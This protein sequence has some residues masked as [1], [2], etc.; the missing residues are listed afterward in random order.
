MDTGCVYGNK[1]TV[2]IVK[3]DAKF[4]LFDDYKQRVYSYFCVGADAVPRKIESLLTSAMEEGWDKQQK[5]A[6]KE[7][8]HMMDREEV[9]EKIRGYTSKPGKE[10]EDPHKE[11]PWDRLRAWSAFQSLVKLGANDRQLGTATLWMYKMAEDGNISEKMMRQFGNM[12]K[13]FVSFMAGL[14]FPDGM[15]KFLALIKYY[16]KAFNGEPFVPHS[17]HETILSYMFAGKFEKALTEMKQRGVMKDK[18][19]PRYKPLLQLYLDVKLYAQGFSDTNSFDFKLPGEGLDEW[20]SDT[21]G[22]AFGKGG[23]SG[24]FW[25]Q[26]FLATDG[27]G[28]PP[29]KERGHIEGWFKALNDD[30]PNITK[31]ERLL[32][33]SNFAREITRI[34]SD[35]HVH[36]YY[37]KDPKFLEII[38]GIYEDLVIPPG[39]TISWKHDK[40]KDREYN[41]ASS[42]QEMREGLKKEQEK[43]PSCLMQDIQI[44]E[45]ICQETESK[46]S[47]VM[48]RLRGASFDSNL[49]KSVEETTQMNIENAKKGILPGSDD[50]TIRLSA[51][52]NRK[53]LTE[54]LKAT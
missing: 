51:E 11:N 4:Q 8:I 46:M 43:D 25:I 5:T 6:L 20:D 52:E 32:F 33:A 21:P 36:K 31:D 9:L 50:D 26:K 17:D 27:S 42:V 28:N 12:G 54:A 34:G 45:N 19:D 22:E 1:L 15:S 39:A 2:A 16:R 37:Y 49:D 3:C 53:K 10:E 7:T 18:N 24:S 23:S 38:F 29:E 35:S 40:Q 44:R 30:N 13:Y 41:T 47:N 14:R 48:H